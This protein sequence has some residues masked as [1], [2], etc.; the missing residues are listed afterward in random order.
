MAGMFQS[1]FWNSK[2]VRVLDRCYYFKIAR[3]S[4][5][6]WNLNEKELNAT[7]STYFLPK[8][9]KIAL[10][11]NLIP[12]WSIYGKNRRS[13]MMKIVER[14]NNFNEYNWFVIIN[15]LCAIINYFSHYFK[16]HLIN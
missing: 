4:S 2:L 15:L 6:S 5:L 16:H 1:K 9:T 12:F 10:E 3:S 11:K 7:A 8:Q 14:F 13:A